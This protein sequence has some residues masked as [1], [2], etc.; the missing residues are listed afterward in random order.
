MNDP[1]RPMKPPRNILLATDL[2]G[3]TDRALDR[4]TQLARQ[5]QA[6]LHIVHVRQ[7]DVEEAF[8][9]AAPAP[10]S[11]DAVHADLIERQI[12]R[13]LH[14]L[15][16]ELAIHVIE[17][18]PAPLILETAAR[19]QCELV[20]LGCRR[21]SFAGVAL[22]STTAQLLRRSPHSLLIVKSRPRG[23]Y[24]QVLVGTDFTTESRHGLETAA[25]WFA[26]ARFM[27]VH[28]LDIPY[29]SLLMQAGRE[30]E[31]SRMEHDAMH[32]FVAA[33]QLPDAVR[34]RLRTQVE[35]GPPEI[36]LRRYGIANDV[37][38]TVVGTLKRG[39]AFRMLVGGNAARIMQTVP[40]DILMVRDGLEV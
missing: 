10:P 20:I 40:G 28:A 27:L 32:A 25:A 7:P 35:Y 24:D 14:E 8:W 34:R 36:M 22:Q 37:D 26:P 11:T 23:A 18:E 4:A 3:H 2:D 9:P 33:A 38:L 13:D 15:P 29:R 17:G 1:A 12:R 31:F 5:W 30:Q 19:E 16:D 21:P 39:L 6:V